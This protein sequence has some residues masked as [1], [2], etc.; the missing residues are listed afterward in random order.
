MKTLAVHLFL[1]RET[2]NFRPKTLHLSALLFYIVLFLLL[3]FSFRV[4]KLTHPDIL[5]FATDINVEKLLNLTNLKRAEAGLPSLNLDPALSIAAAGKANDMFGKNYWAHNAPDGTTPW[6]FITNSGYQYIFAGENLAKDFGNSEG[7]VNAWMTSPSH[8]DNILKN[9]YQDVGFAVVNGRLAGEDTTL[10]VQFF[11]TPQPVSLVSKP[12]SIPPVAATV[13]FPSPTPV[14]PLVSSSALPTP[15]PS[16]ASIGL[17]KERIPP[18]TLSSLKAIG[19]SRRPL[20]DFFAT[21]K[22]LASLLAGVLL[23]VL[24]LDGVIIWRRRIVRISGHNVAH[25]IFLAGLLVALWV[26][27]QGVIV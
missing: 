5:G 7:V 16:P 6:F 15:I 19:L 1:P 23:L 21:S 26:T 8:R 20:I 22:N 4:I 27:N 17:V 3:Q 10:V 14:V 13:S 12:V 18:S 11:G 24:I 25:I 9:E 2:N